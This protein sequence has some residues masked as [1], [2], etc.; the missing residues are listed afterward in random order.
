MRGWRWLAPAVVVLLAV[1]AWPI[2]RGVWLSLRPT[3]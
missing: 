1:T 3:R 2:G